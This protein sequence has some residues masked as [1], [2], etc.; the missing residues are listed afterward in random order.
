VSLDVRCYARWPEATTE[1]DDDRCQLMMGH[2][3]PHALVVAAPGERQLWAWRGTSMSKRGLRDG[4]P[5]QLC[6]APGMPKSCHPVTRLARTP[7]VSARTGATPAAA[8]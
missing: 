3:P 4:V 1:L 5:Y 6:W 2:E 7:A 8:R